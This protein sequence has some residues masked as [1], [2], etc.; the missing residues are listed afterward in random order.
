MKSKYLL[1][2]MLSTGLTALLNFIVQIYIAR[3]SSIEVFGMYSVYNTMILMGI[4]IIT[5]GLSDLILKQMSEKNNISSRLDINILFLIFIYCFIGF[6]LLNYF[7]SWYFYDGFFEKKYLLF[8]AVGVFSYVFHELYLAYLTGTQNKLFLI[9]WQPCL[10]FVRFFIL[11]ILVIFYK[12]LDIENVLEMAVVSSVVI[13][14]IVS[15]NFKNIF[16]IRMRDL[17]FYKIL[18]ISRNGFWF[19]LSGI[20][21]IIY[22]QISS[23][24]VGK[25]C[26]AEEAGYFNIGYTFLL[27]SLIVPNTIYTKILLPKLHRSVLD[28]PAYLKYFYKKGAMILLFFGILVSF[29]LYMLSEYILL[30]FYG[31]KYLVANDIFRKII[32][33]IPLFYMVIHY[34]IYSYLN[35]LQK[36]KA[37]VLAL[38]TLFSLILNYILVSYFGI[39]GAAMGISIVLTFIIFL[40]IYL[41]KNIIFEC[42]K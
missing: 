36:Y 9:L 29:I 16:L 20:F 2:L 17:S 3:N 27:M 19:G 26:G 41:N 38:T 11:I 33:N 22:S 34:G 10:H 21:Y 18:D 14:F 37:L 4:P 35:N 8:M 6:I 40:Y 42:I 28:N 23:L 30:Y 31:D 25:F 1:F 32:I 13:F 7:F 15:I 5:M 39:D 12:K 24:Y